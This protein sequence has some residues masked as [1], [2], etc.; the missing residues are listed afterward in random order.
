MLYLKKAEFV[1]QFDIAIRCPLDCVE[2]RDWEYEV[3]RNVD[4]MG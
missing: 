3:C 2:I 4:R 1:S